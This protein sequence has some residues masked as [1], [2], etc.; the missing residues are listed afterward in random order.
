[1]QYDLLRGSEG[2]DM[3]SAVAAVVVGD[4]EVIPSG[5]N[6]AILQGALR[7]IQPNQ[8]TS[9]DEKSSTDPFSN[10]RKILQASN[11]LYLTDPNRV[12]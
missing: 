2:G 3:G 6:R 5:E 1:M 4:S 7:P 8:G 11:D 12:L 10:P 9:Y